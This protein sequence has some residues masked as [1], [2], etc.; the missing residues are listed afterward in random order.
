LNPSR[1]YIRYER[2]IYSRFFATIRDWPPRGPISVERWDDASFGA[3]EGRDVRN[4][5]TNPEKQ[6]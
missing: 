6:Y 4:S 5:G 3:P 2:R 1:I